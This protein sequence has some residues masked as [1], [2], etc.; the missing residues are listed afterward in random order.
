MVATEMKYMYATIGFSEIP[1]LIELYEY[2]LE[3]LFCILL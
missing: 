3:Y 1:C 2:Y